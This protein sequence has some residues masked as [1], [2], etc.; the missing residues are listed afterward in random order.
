MAYALINITRYKRT[1]EIATQYSLMH[2]CGVRS[3]AILV[4]GLMQ[5]Y[6]SIMMRR[7]LSILDHGV[8]C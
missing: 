5:R 7:T 2:N 3:H 8:T 4:Y 1:Q 6:I